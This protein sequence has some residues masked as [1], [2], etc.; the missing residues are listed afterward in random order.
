MQKNLRLLVAI[1]L[2]LGVSACATAPNPEKVCTTDWIETRANKAVSRIEGRTHASMKSLKSAAK[3]WSRGKTPGPFQMLAL[4]RS[5]KGLEK[6]LT[7]GRGIKDL[8]ILANTCDDPKIVSKAMGGFLR[9][10]GLP[11]NIINFVENMEQYKSLLRLPTVSAEN[12]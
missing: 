5:L 4:S 6:E 9:N 2:T 10:Q 12:Q 7:S 1:T 3:S 11:E 8:K